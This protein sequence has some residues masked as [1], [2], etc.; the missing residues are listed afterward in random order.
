M[1]IMER[2]R[3]WIIVA[4]VSLGALLVGTGAMVAAIR[5]GVPM[6]ALVLVAAVI[7][8]A[9]TIPL[10]LRYPDVAVGLLLV[11]DLTR[12]SEITTERV[13][14]PVFQ[15]ILVLAIASLVLGFARGRLRLRWTPVYLLVLGLLAV[16]GLSLLA[17]GGGEVGITT[18]VD[19]SK[20][21]V[22]LAVVLVW[23]GSNRSLKVATGVLVVTLASLAAL[24]VIQEY[25]FANSTYFLG[26]SNVDTAQPGAA[27]LRHT[28]PEFDANFW[29]R[30]LVVVLPIA[31]SWLALAKQNLTRW[32]AGGAAVA[33][34][35]GIY[36]T[37]SR[38][39]LIAAGAAVAIWLVMAGRP[40]IRWL[41]LAP[42]VLA[43]L[44]A[45]PGVG[46]RLVTLTDFDGVEQGAGDPSLQGRVGAQRAGVGMFLDYPILGIGFGEFRETVPE[47]QRKLGI[48]A[49]VLDAHNLYLEIAAETGVIGLVA[50]GLFIG[51][52]L[53]V[54][55]RAW[56]ISGQSG[57]AKD[58]WIHLMAAGVISGLTAWLIA[59]AFL[60]ASNLR[61]LFAVIAVGVGLDLWAREDPMVPT[62]IDGPG[63]SSVYHE[64]ESPSATNGR[65]PPLIL[66]PALVVP[67][68]LFA[69][70]ASSILILRS[71]PQQW[72]AERYVVMATGDQA[73]SRYVA[74][75]YDLITRGVVGG[76]YAAL[77]EEPE[78]TQRAVAELGW[79]EA[80]LDAIEVST[81]YAQG[82]QVITLRV[83]G[84]DP[85]KV[86][87]AADA[88]VKYGTGFVTALDEPFVVATVESQPTDPE[89]RANPELWRIGLLAVMGTT[90]I[91]GIGWSVSSSRQRPTIAESIR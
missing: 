13:G 70:A 31:M 82:S 84:D 9:I 15:P 35:F 51:F 77:L 37:Q 34:G 24:S 61:I 88:I 46:S 33:I 53:F 91:V 40:Y 76:T 48:Q 10:A 47:F 74:Y 59:S 49:E 89:Q 85:D 64:D 39:G 79:D 25:V 18:L 67:L 6:M 62:G 44:L 8:A 42:V 26:L 16:G 7:V 21:I 63:E 68:L 66:R 5:S 30:S 71:A 11:A 32:M 22:F 19:F 55:L 20:D 27:T 38:G 12:L 69:V 41:V 17:V 50:W 86:R 1:R 4:A 80:D 43:V 60:H 90:A 29:A 52:G 83:A 56:L 28:G 75:S 57:S 36:L 3:L 2:S 65:Q 81:S 14:V 87:A 45:I 73:D 58:R 54:A 78:I 23:V 72:V